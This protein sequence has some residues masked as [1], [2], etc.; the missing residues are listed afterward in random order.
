M[1]MTFATI[2]YAACKSP[3]LPIRPYGNDSRELSVIAR[4]PY[5]S[6]DG[7]GQDSLAAG[8]IRVL[9]KHLSDLGEQFYGG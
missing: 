1:L 9:S 6:G 4:V 5:G 3:L 8:M 2:A 7:R